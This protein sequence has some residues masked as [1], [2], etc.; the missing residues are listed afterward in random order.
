MFLN[1][2]LI[3]HCRCCAEKLNGV[4]FFFSF[5]SSVEFNA[6]VHDT[7]NRMK[8]VVGNLTSTNSNSSIG[9]DYNSN[10][11][12]NSHIAEKS[13]VKISVTKLGH[14]F[15]VMRLSA[16]SNCMKLVTTSVIFS[17]ICWF[18]CGCRLCS[19]LTYTL[20]R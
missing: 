13:T 6:S 7:R 15:S 20:H 4:G 1:H 16:T 18:H 9:N 3:L 10:N 8:S 12:S 2:T 19:K 11:N 14:I 5:S 17:W